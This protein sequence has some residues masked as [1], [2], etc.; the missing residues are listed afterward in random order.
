MFIC[1]W[2]GGPALGDLWDSAPCGYSETSGSVTGSLE[3]FQ[4]TTIHY[5]S[6]PACRTCY[7]LRH[8]WGWF[9]QVF[10]LPPALVGIVFLAWFLCYGMRP[11]LSEQQKAQAQQDLV[12]K[13]AEGLPEVVRWSQAITA[14]FGPGFFD[15]MTHQDREEIKERL[16]SSRGPRAFRFEVLEADRDAE[17]LWIEVWTGQPPSASYV[18]LRGGR[19]GEKRP[20][21]VR[22]DWVRL[23]GE[24]EMVEANGFRFVFKVTN[25]GAD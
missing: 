14:W 19:K 4:G 11:G 6:V 20:I 3:T 25:V 17:A 21:P 22:D 18:P 7:E 24:L 12:L 8:R 13:H 10:L 5:E 15:R 23:A 9:C 2:C 1:H 16:R